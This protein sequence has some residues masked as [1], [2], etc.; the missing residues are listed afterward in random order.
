MPYRIGKFWPL[1]IW[2]IVLLLLNPDLWIIPTL[3]AAGVPFQRV[4]VVALIAA[5]LDLF[6]TYWCWHRTW[7][8]LVEVSKVREVRRE[9]KKDGWFDQ[10]FVDYVLGFYWDVIDPES[11]FSRK[12]RNWGFPLLLV[13]C[14]SPLP[15]PRTLTA[16]FCAIKGHHKCIILLVACDLLHVAGAAYLWEF[17]FWFGHQAAALL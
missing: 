10:G 11:K 17:V 8:E 4:L 15:G 1:A 16:I 9:L 13:G 6:Y 14:A 12:M 2:P 5:L 7:P 3:R